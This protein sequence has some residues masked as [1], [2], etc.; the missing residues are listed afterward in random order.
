[1]ILNTPTSG[2]RFDFANRKELLAY[3]QQICPHAKSW[4]AE[5][6][7]LLGEGQPAAEK[8]QNIDSETST[9]PRI[10]P[11]RDITA[12]IR[13]GMVTLDEI[14]EKVLRK[15]CHPEDATKLIQELAWRDYFQRLYRELGIGLWEDAELYKTGFLAQEY[16]HQLPKD[17]QAG[18]TGTCMDQFIHELYRTGYLP[19]RARRWLAAYI[20][21]WRRVRWQTGAQWYLMHLSDGDPA[22]NNLSWQWVASTFSSKPYFYNLD[23]LKASG[24]QVEGFNNRP[25]MGSSEAISAKL[26]PGK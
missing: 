2:F 17:V 13:Q 19:N 11:D 14:R 6:L 15:V 21:H 5:I 9:R 23:A 20:V 26:F 4:G 8:G 1:M 18:E 24:V 16:D 3:V 22:S 10:N 25:F 12:F 7:P